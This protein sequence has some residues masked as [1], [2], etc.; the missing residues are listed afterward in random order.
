MKISILKSCAGLTFSFI[1]GQDV[2]VKEELAKERNSVFG[3][4]NGDL[5]RGLEF[6]EKEYR[7]IDKY[8]KEKG[9]LHSEVIFVGDDYGIGG[10]D[11][12]VYKSDFGSDTLC[13]FSL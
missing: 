4:T 10:N 7:E 3:K 5:K 13:G 8:C 11:E 2:D 1:E 9:V 6:G 12:S